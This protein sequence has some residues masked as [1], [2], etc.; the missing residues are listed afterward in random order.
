MNRQI[1]PTLSR[2]QA[3]TRL[4]ADKEQWKNFAQRITKNPFARAFILE[5][6]GDRCAWCNCVMLKRKIIHHITYEHHCG[7]NKVIR[8]TTPT[9]GYPNKTR[10]VPDCEGCRSE[11]KERF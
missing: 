1:I 11:N 3:R 8:I 7:Y 10:I 4:V 2:A 6:D 5:R 9:P